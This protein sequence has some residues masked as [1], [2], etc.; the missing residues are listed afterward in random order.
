M[1]TGGFSWV[2]VLEMGMRVLQ[3][4]ASGSRLQAA[5]IDKADPVFQIFPRAA[6]PWCF[7]TVCG[8][9]S[10]VSFPYPYE[11]QESFHYGCFY[12]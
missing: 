4:P 8:S 1:D 5:G 12:N 7:G 2:R 3:R 9:S 6:L 10:A 11:R